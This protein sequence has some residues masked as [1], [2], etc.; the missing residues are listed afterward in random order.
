MTTNALAPTLDT[1]KTAPEKLTKL[2]ELANEMTVVAAREP[3]NEAFKKLAWYAERVH[4]V[5]DGDW[6]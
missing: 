2:R 5:L 6:A 1:R 3:N 4:R